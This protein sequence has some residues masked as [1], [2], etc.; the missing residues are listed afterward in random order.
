MKKITFYLSVFCLLLSTSTGFAQPQGTVYMVSNAHLDSQWNWDVRLSIDAFVKNTLTQ[1]LWLLERYPDYVFNFEGGIKYA[2]MKEYYP[3]EYEKIKPYIKNGRWH[4]SGASWDAADPNMPAPESFFRSVLLAQKLYQEEFGVK[5]TD[6]FLPDC[7]GFGWQLPTLAAHCGLIGFST[8]KLQWRAKPFHGDLK[9]PFKIGLWQGIDGSKIIAALDGRAYVKR[10]DGNDIT[11]DEEL[12]KLAAE[13]PN[14]KAFRYYGTGDIGGSPTVRSVVSIE[15]SIT[16]PQGPLKIVSATSDQ[17]FKEYLPYEDHPELPVYN[18]ELTMDVHATGCYTSQAAMKQYNR[19]NE[20]LAV[21]AET[22]AAIADQMGGLS[23]PAEKLTENWKRFLWH[24][25]HDDLTGTSIP[26]AYTYSWNDEILCMNQ[27]S[28]M[29]TASTQNIAQQLNTQGKGKPV[30]VYNSLAQQRKEVVVATV[31]MQSNVLGV[32]V[33]APN[34][35]KIKAQLMDYNYEDRKATVAFAANVPPMSFSVYD[36]CPGAQGKSTNLKVSVGDNLSAIE[37]SCYK[38]TLDNNGDIVS[39]YDKK[40]KKELVKANHPIRLALFTENE[41][42][43]WPAWEILKETI[44][45]EPISITENVKISKGTVGEV[46]ATLIIE[47]TYGNSTFKQTIR[48]TEG[49]NDDRIDIMNDIDW[50]TQN[51]LLKAEFPLAVSN[52]NARYDIGMGSI[53]RGNNTDIAYEVFAQQW[54]DLT[55]VSGEYGVTIMNNCKYGWDK[56]N[57]NTLRLTLLHT[58]KTEKRYIYQN[59]QDLGKHHFTFSIMGHQGDFAEAGSVRKADAMNNPLFAFNTNAHTGK[60]KMFSFVKY[61]VANMEIKA[62]KK[63][64]DGN[65]YVV[66]IYE[67][68]GQ[69]VNNGE[70]IFAFPIKKAVETNGIEE[71]IGAATFSGNKLIV[72]T[73]AYKPKTYRVW[74]ETSATKLATPKSLIIDLPF[75]AEGYTMDNFLR[76]GN[77][78]GKEH[79]YAYELLPETLYSE[80]TPFKFGQFGWNNIILCDSNI[81]TLPAEAK[82][83]KT[84]YLLAA[85]AEK[86]GSDATYIVNEKTVTCHIPYFSDFYGQWY[87]AEKPAYQRDANVAYVGTHRHDRTTGNESYIYTYMYKIAI[88][89]TSETTQIVLPKDKKVIIFS[90]TLSDEV[91]G[92]ITPAGAFYEL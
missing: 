47:K 49:A 82:N 77:V 69:S 41:S 26:E 74:F 35:E 61:D 75:N 45:R 36:V 16:H 34:G 56:P 87:T 22:T 11:A 15:K 5:S 71:E 91:N 59:R 25:F 7:F 21:A 64:D 18:G 78:D 55:D 24:Q 4:I 70:I 30:I 3:A 50:Q 84:L 73:T 58:P 62:F 65:G 20:Q 51:A 10:Y 89:I 27:L 33:Y 85:S 13:S 37:N 43:N 31:P 46:F 19:R 38:I 39:I 17:L 1:N 29:I 40:A 76:T 52:P 44:D 23:Y 80:G 6:V 67:T 28:D 72:N 8:Q 86:E 90:A 2:W 42:K 63:A 12:L 60:T 53:E 68:A 79:T 92:K 54:A 66:R 88:P 57:D 14:N 81:I 48:L 32:T 83:Y 9:M